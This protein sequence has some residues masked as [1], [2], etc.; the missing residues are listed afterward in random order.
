MEGKYLLGA[1]EGKGVWVGEQ[2]R[3]VIKEEVDKETKGI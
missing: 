3:P 2:R 1:K